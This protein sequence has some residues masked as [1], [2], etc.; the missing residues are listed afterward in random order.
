MDLASAHVSVS[1]DIT[2]PLSS[3]LHKWQETAAL[4]QV[5]GV[6]LSM[7]SWQME[8]NFGCKADQYIGSNTD[9]GQ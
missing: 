3:S 5:L 8:L 7:E 4:H 1:A 9:L 6:F 2:L